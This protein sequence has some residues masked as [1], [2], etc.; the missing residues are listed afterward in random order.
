MCAEIETGP[1]GGIDAPKLLEAAYQRLVLNLQMSPRFL[2]SGPSAENWRFSKQLGDSPDNKSP[3]V[4]HERAIA[5]LTGVEW[6]NQIPAASG[7][8]NSTA[9]KRRAVDL[10]HRRED[11]CFELIEL[12][13]E[14]DTPL[15]AAVEV[16]QYGLLYA[17]AR[18]HYGERERASKE[19]LQ[20]KIVH[21]RVLA[22]SE[23]YVPYQLR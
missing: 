7:L 8:W 1:A 19:L 10:V 18:A 14:S 17:L 12:K 21:L 16:I 11:G 15:R 5:R 9:D 20:A 2:T 23:Y 13:V 3:E 4:T 22:P 6:A